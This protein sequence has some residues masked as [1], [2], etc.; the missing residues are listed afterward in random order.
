MA[1]ATTFTAEM[2][3]LTGNAGGALQSLPDVTKVGG[4]VRSF[5]GQITL[6]AQASGSTIG[7]ARLP[8]GASILGIWVC[9]DT[10][11]S[12][13]AV[14]VG[15]SN[16]ATRFAP[17]NTLTATNTPTRWGNAATMGVQITSGYDCVT[18]SATTAGSYFDV[19]FV[20][21]VASLPGSG[22]LSF[23]IE[24]VFD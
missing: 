10:S 9:T 22:T 11:L 4:R 20:T 14:S 5:R 23:V 19:V 24:Y 17:A 18:G 15:D 21:S 12:T 7:I 1:V 2:T 3:S 6:A 13:A 8:M 16:T